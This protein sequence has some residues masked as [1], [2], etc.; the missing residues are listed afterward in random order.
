M[1][2]RHL[3]GGTVERSPIPEHPTSAD[4][5]VLTELNSRLR[6]D[7]SSLP[8]ELRAWLDAHLTESR[9][10]RASTDPHG[11]STVA[12]WVV[13]DHIGENDS[14]S[15]V[16]YDAQRGTFGPVTELENGLLWYQ[17][18]HGSL[19]DAVPGL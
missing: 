5:G 6:N 3:Q 11:M 8:E 18:P 14:S 10:I 7:A 1:S 13:S 4:A 2:I 15:R 9:Q 16:V 19:V 12:V 17:G